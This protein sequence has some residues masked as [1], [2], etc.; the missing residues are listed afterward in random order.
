M[1]YQVRVAVSEADRLGAMDVRRVVFIEEQGVPAAIEMDELDGEA[2]HII[3]VASAGVVG[4]ARLLQLEDGWHIGRVAVLAE[5]RKCGIGSALMTLA[6]QC[7]RDR[8]AGEVI[9]HSQTTAIPFYTSLGYVAEG[10]EFLEA[11]I[12][13]RR[14]WLR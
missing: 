1:S 10:P 5:W 9:I 12:A 4:T 7:A 11:G 6:A 13:H 2:V 3:A 14:M 8:G